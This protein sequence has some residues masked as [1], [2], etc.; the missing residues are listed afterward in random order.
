MFATPIYLTR[1]LFFLLLATAAASAK[2]P[3]VD[4]TSGTAQ[5]YYPE[6][7]VRAFL[8]IPYAQPPVKSLRFRSPLPIKQKAKGVIDA[9]RFGLSCYQY[10][11]GVPGAT[12]LSPT[13]GESED[14]LTI[15][16]WTSDRGPRSA[17]SVFVFMYGGAFAEGTSAIPSMSLDTPGR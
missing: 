1:S 12:S 10:R 4:T 8:G 6:P 15:N 17:K 9:T 11:T 14:C 7:D 13:T 5:G 16:V 2:F 3:L